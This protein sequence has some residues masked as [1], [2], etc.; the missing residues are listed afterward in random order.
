M[1]FPA[2]C[3]QIGYAKKMHVGEKAYFSS[4]YLIHEIENGLYEIIQVTLADE[5][6]LLRTVLHTK[7]LARHDEICV[8]PERVQLHNRADLIF[9]A[10]RTGKKCTLFTGTDEH[11]NFVYD[12]YVSVL[13]PIHV[14]DLIPPFPHLSETLQALEETGIFGELEIY[15][16]H[17]IADIRDIHADVYPC[18][19]GGTKRSIDNDRLFEGETVAGCMTARLILAECYDTDF[20]LHDICPANVASASNTSPYIVRCCRIEREG[21]VQ[22]EN[23]IGHIVHWGASPKI[24]CDAVFELVSMYRKYQNS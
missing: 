17:H 13:Q 18:R 21:P 20:D 14:Y 5:P 6:V 12:P 22:T 16:K 8:Y 9:R 7:V 15:F 3:K 2:K 4:E 24:I 23:Q 10:T 1:L 11:M 19:A